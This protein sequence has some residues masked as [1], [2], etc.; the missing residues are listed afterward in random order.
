MISYIYFFSFFI[1]FNS[2]LSCQC[3]LYDCKYVHLILP[4][5]NGFTNDK[6]YFIAASTHSPVHL[7][8]SLVG[9]FC[10]CPMFRNSAN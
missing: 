9:I 5:I 2:G 1:V 6:K 4:A 7:V 10:Q 3:D 8:G